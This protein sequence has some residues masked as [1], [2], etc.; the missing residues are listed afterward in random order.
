[1]IALVNKKIYPNSLFFLLAFFLLSS[2]SQHHPASQ[3]KPLTPLYWP[4]QS[5]KPVIQYIGVFSNAAELGISPGFW[6]RLLEVFSGAADSHLVRPMAVVTDQQGIIYVADPGA[7]GVHRFD[8]ENQ[9]YALIQLKD[10][11]PLPSPVGLLLDNQSN[12]IISDSKLATLYKVIRGE[13]VANKFI[14]EVTFK[15]PT[16]LTAGSDNDFYVVDTAQHKIINLNFN[17]QLI[18]QFGRRGFANAEFN[19]PTMISFT[20][21][22][23]LVTDSLNFRIQ[24]LDSHGKFISKFGQAGDATGYHYR[25]KGIATDKNKNI[26][27]VD[28]LFHTVQLFDNVGKFLM[29][30]GEPGQADGQFWLPTGI[31][32]DHQD[33]IYV[34]D[35]Y[36]KRIQMF[37]ILGAEQ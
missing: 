21:K 18:D 30:F 24:R 14:T 11:Q 3:T 34:A 27:V 4:A 1:M 15:Q 25:P 37:R 7:K 23:L 33:I 29:Y 16:G 26:Y 22:Q 12:L 31:F 10:E 35:S 8:R 9:S 13:T 28:G 36:N 32:I 5:D 19:Y 2:C 17:G 6:T 20:D